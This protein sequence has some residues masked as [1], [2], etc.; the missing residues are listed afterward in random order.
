MRLMRQLFSLFDRRE[1]LQIFGLAAMLLVGSFFDVIGIGLVLPFMKI[2][3]DPS[4]LLQNR[5]AGPFLREIGVTDPK[6]VIIGTGL[7]LLALFLSKN[8]FLAY[9]WRI[10]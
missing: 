5:F 10:M 4:I 2:A 3:S 6:S 1:R 7:V 9:E 8:A